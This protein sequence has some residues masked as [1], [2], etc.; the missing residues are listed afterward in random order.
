MTNG[1]ED[2]PDLSDSSDFEG[3][4]GTIAAR[5][6]CRAKVARSQDAKKLKVKRL[7]GK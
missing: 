2:I 3:L 5:A 1:S 6:K 7:F 4:N